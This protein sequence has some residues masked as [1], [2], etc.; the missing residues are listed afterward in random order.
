MT[1]NVSKQT[2]LSFAGE[3]FLYLDELTSQ[4]N[5]AIHVFGVNPTITAKLRDEVTTH[6]PPL[7]YPVYLL[8][9]LN[10]LKYYSIEPL[11]VHILGC[12]KRSNM[13]LADFSGYNKGYCCTAA[14]ASF[15]LSYVIVATRTTSQIIDK[16]ECTFTER[17]RTARRV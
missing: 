8:W 16:M 5:D 9:A 10:F 14:P 4:T 12:S 7:I 13:C 1:P 6:L 15:I 2:F 17:Y 3:T 11:N